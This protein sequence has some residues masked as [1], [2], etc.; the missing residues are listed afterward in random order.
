[1]RAAFAAVVST[2]NISNRDLEALFRARLT[3]I[4]TGFASSSFVEL[5][6]D[7]IVIHA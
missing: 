5:E 7:S 4:V 6:R 1:M 3:L 2:G